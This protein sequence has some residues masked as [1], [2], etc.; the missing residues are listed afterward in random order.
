MQA[1]SIPETSVSFHRSARRDIPEDSL[2][3]QFLRAKHKTHAASRKLVPVVALL[4]ILTAP[5]NML[6]N[7]H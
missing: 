5:V 7:S 4:V 2:H 1:V 6:P 3:L